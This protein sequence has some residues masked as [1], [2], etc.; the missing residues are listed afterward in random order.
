MDKISIL[1]VLLLVAAGREAFSQQCL[2]GDCKSGSGTM[3]WSTGDRYEGQFR[4]GTMEGRGTMT[5]KNG[6]VYKGLWVRGKMQ[7]NGVMTWPNGDRYEGTFLNNTMSTFGTMAYANGTRYT[8]MWTNGRMDKMGTMTWKNGDKYEGSFSNGKRE[9]RGTMTWKS[10]DKYS[11]L[12]KNDLMDG[13]GTMTYAGKKVVK[14]LWKNGKLASEEKPQSAIPAPSG[15]YGMH[16]LLNPGDSRYTESP[17]WT[18]TF[19]EGGTGTYRRVGS[20][21]EVSGKI[22]WKLEGK[23]LTMTLQGMEDGPQKY[24]YDGAKKWFAKKPEPYGPN[25]TV[26]S[27]CIIKK[28]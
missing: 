21:T 8:G 9:G 11:G 14:G 7:G 6:V 25:G 5:Y 12:W 10:G 24:D 13:E 23:T 3:T 1:V 28:K 20:E 17:A 27:V 19:A 15:T 2:K 26:V 22:A 4:N 18:F 16:C